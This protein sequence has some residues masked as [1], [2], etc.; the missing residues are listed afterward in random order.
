VLAGLRA[1]GREVDEAAWTEPVR[2]IE[3][4]PARAGIYAEGYG[5]YLARVAAAR[6][7]WG[8]ARAAR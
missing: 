5:G 7:E 1:L 4:D 8:G 6:A 2:V 3:P